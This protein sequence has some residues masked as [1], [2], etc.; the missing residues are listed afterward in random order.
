MLGHR[1]LGGGHHFVVFAQGQT[2][3][4]PQLE[5]V[6]AELFKPGCLGE[7]PGCFGHIHQGWAVEAIQCLTQEAG[8]FPG[9]APLEGMATLAALDLEQTAVDFVICSVDQVTTVP[10]FDPARAKHPTQKRHVALKGR[11]PA[12]GRLALPQVLGQAWGGDQL[13]GDGQQTHQKGS[14]PEACHLHLARFA[15]D[16]ERPEDLELHRSPHHTRGPR[17]YP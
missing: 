16:D 2:G 10:A 3:V 11:H 7:G 8:C 12:G 1:C 15:A 4:E 6:Q 13:V 5:G 17:L 9:I 14:A